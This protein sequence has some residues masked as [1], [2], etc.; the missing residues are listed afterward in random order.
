MSTIL[1]KDCAF[2]IPHYFS[3]MFEKRIGTLFRSIIFMIAY[4]FVYCNSFLS[5]LFISS[6]RHQLGFFF[7]SNQ[8]AAKIVLIVQLPIIASYN[9]MVL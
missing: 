4:L 5:I 1:I 6:N 8:D 7:H 2:D 9:Q 3:E